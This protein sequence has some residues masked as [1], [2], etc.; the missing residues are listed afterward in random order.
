MLKLKP[1]SLDWALAHVNRF[2]DTSMLPVPFEY[3]AIEHNWSDV[4][5]YLSEQDILNW[6]VRA[7]RTLLAPKSRYVFRIITQLDPLDFLG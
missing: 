7:H 3:S 1:A 2:D 5:S 4:R 6:K